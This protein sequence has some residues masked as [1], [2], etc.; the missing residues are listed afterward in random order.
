MDDKQRGVPSPEAVENANTSRQ[1]T[2]VRV[3]SPRE[4][5]DLV[6]GV[7]EVNM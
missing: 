4:P 1:A 3:K 2:R 5:G 7:G 6:M